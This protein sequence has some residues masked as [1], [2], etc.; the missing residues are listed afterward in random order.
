MSSTTFETNSTENLTRTGVFV[1]FPT[2]RFLSL[3]LARIYYLTSP[4]PPSLGTSAACVQSSRS[5][6][7]CHRTCHASVLHLRSWLLPAFESYPRPYACHFSWR[8]S[9]TFKIS[10]GG[11]IC[12]AAVDG[13]HNLRSQIRWPQP[14]CYGPHLFTHQLTHLQGRPSSSRDFSNKLEDP[15]SPLTPYDRL[16]L[17]II[18]SFPH[19]R[20][21]KTL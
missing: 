10:G 7:R 18:L 14:P 15:P 11:D 17:P 12:C 20:C 9:I 6:N 13:I 5:R 2:I 8:P 3:R 16:D 19:A 4:A 21:P 1:A